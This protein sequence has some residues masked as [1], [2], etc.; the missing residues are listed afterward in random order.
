MI[1]LARKEGIGYNSRELVM[2]QH[3]R[4]M[5]ANI[6]HLPSQIPSLHKSGVNELVQS[7]MDNNTEL[8]LD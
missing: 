5:K 3:L 2:V 8:V 1:N 4:G 6:H 7:L